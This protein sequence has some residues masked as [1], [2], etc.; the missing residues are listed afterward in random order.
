MQVART[1]GE[2]FLEQRLPVGAV[3]VEIRIPRL[4]YQRSISLVP[5]EE[6][7][8]VDTLRGVQTRLSQLGFLP[9]EVDGKADRLTRDALATFK[10][11]RGLPE[12]GNLDKA[13]QDALKEAYGS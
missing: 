13:T 1:D 10:K 2:G 7:P 12:D 11:S 3:L 5:S 9:K 8:T 4:D 6:F